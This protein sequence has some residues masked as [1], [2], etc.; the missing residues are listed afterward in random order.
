MFEILFMSAN[1]GYHPGRLSSSFLFQAVKSPILDYSHFISL[2]LAIHPSLVEKLNHF[3]CSILG[4]S[5]NVDSDKGEDLSE[6]SMDEIDHE[7]KQE[8]S[9]SVSIKMQAHEESVRVKM[10]IKGS[11]PGLKALLIFLLF[12]FIGVFLLSTL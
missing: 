2:P 3:Q 11:Q 8:R 10:D 5:S 6:G 1:H 4:T 12:R 7:Q 9:P